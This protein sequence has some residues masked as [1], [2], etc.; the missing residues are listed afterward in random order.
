MLWLHF[1]AIRLSTGQGSV[2]LV[3][4]SC[5]F[6]YA[7]DV[8]SMRRSCDGEVNVE[9]KVRPGRVDHR[10]DLNISMSIKSPCAAGFSDDKLNGD[11]VKPKFLIIV[12]T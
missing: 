10:L 3:M 11:E 8:R 1:V 9:R 2:R 4:F 5:F 7:W 6:H 12:K